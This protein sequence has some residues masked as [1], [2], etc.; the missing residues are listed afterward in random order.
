MGDRS[1]NDSD[2]QTFELQTITGGKVL[3]LRLSLS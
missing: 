1:Q 3:D 2:D